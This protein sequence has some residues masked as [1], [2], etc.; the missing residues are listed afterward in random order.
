VHVEW[1]GQEIET[2]VKKMNYSPDWLQTFEINV[3]TQLD[4]A[5]AIDE[6]LMLFVMDWDRMG[7]NDVVGEVLFPAQDLRAAF[8]QDE[9]LEGVYAVYEEG[10]SRRTKNEME[11]RMFGLSRGVHVKGNDGK[12]TT[13]ELSIKASK[14]RVVVEAAKEVEWVYETPESARAL[15]EEFESLSAKQNAEGLDVARRLHDEMPE[16]LD[17]LAMFTRTDSPLRD[18]IAVIRFHELERHIAETEA[19]L[20]RVTSL[21][22]TI[23]SNPKFSD[24]DVGVLPY[25]RRLHQEFKRNKLHLANLRFVIEDSR[26]K[27]QEIEQQIHYILFPHLKRP[28]KRPSHPPVVMIIEVLSGARCGCF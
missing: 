6:D 19:E 14:T 8:A 24:H 22:H 26:R 28:P 7:D 3:D 18:E 4:A 17:L 15:F 5:H 9:S 27:K 2:E 13:I 10:S 25:R 12:G 20:D 21:Q 16:G 23:E 1:L 11:R